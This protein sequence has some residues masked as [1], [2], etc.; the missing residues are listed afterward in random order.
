[1]DRL[2]V[3]IRAALALRARRLG[4]P[5]AP[6]DTLPS[7][8]LVERL[9]V[10]CA[11][12]ALVIERVAAG[13]VI[14]GGAR[15]RL[16]LRNWEKPERGGR[17]WV[18]RELTP[19][20]QVFSI[21]HELG[22]FILHRGE[23]ATP[24]CPDEAISEDANI[25]LLRVAREGLVEEYNPKARREL[26]ANAFAAELLAPGYETRELFLASPSCDENRIA[27]MF[28]VSPRLARARLVASVLSGAE[29]ARE[30]DAPLEGEPPPVLSEDERRALAG[31]LLGDLDEWQREAAK[32]SG[33]AL[34][35]AGPGTGKTKTLVGRVA[36]LYG[37]RGA[38]PENIL[39]LTF[40]NRAADEMR[41]RL[42]AAGLP[43]ERTP[44]MTIHAFATELLRR[45]A[46]YVP[47]AEDEPPLPSDFRILDGLDQL[48][49]AEELL[50][51]LG[52]R[53]LRRLNDPAAPL[54]ELL[55]RFSWARDH[56]LTPDGYR[57]LVDAMPLAPDDGDG[58]E[59]TREGGRG[60]RNGKSA[61]KLPE[62]TF[63]A[64]Q[65]EQAREQ[66]QAY[67]VWDR[68]LRLRGLLD[69]GGL[70]QRA[71]ETLRAAPETLAEA[72]VAFPHVL[73]DEF[74]DTNAAAAELLFLLA[75]AGGKGLWVV[76]DRNQS[77]YRWRGASPNNLPELTRRYPHLTVRTLRQSYRSVPDI[78]RLG[79]DMA[80]RMA[81]LSAEIPAMNGRSADGAAHGP[82]AEALRPVAL[83]AARM[84]NGAPAVWRGEAFP[85]PQAEHAAIIADMLR[86]HADG[87]A[88]SDM[89]ALCYKSKF[90]RALAAELTARGIPVTA[91]G[92]FFARDE[93][94]D[95]LALLR[96][97]ASHDAGGLLRARGLLALQGIRILTG[98]DERAL[99]RAVRRMAGAGAGFPWSLRD[100]DALR[101]V[102]TPEAL[103]PP[104][105]EVG[106]AAADLWWARRG[107]NQRLA[108]LLLRPSGLAWRLAR[109]AGR[110]DPPTAPDDPLG[111]P[112][113]APARARDALAALGALVSLAARFDVRWAAEPG[114]RQQLSGL[115]ARD[116]EEEKEADLTPSPSPERRG[117]SDSSP[118]EEPERVARCFLRYIATLARA[119]DEVVIPPGEEDAVHVLTIH[120][121]KGLEFSAVYLF[122]LAP[123]GFSGSGRNAVDP[124][125][126]ATGDKLDAHLEEQEAERRSLLYVAATRA[127]DTLTITR[128]L[129]YKDNG[130]N[131][132]PPLPAATILDVSDIY[133]SAATLPPADA[134]DYT[135][136]VS[137]DADGDEDD[138]EKD[139]DGEPVILDG[140][141]AGNAKPVFT[142]YALDMYTDCPRRYRYRELY[143]LRDGT[144]PA[145]GA[146][147]RFV[148]RGLDE[149]RRMRAERPD[150]DGDGAR[151]ALATLW[152]SQ[153]DVRGAFGAMYKGYALD[154]LDAEWE[155][156]QD[157][158]EAIRLE[159][160]I[161]LRECAVQLNVDA[162]ITRDPG[163]DQVIL[164]RWH[165]GRP[166]DKH[167]QDP[168]LPLMLMG[169]RQLDPAAHVSVRLVY[170][171]AP[172]GEVGAASAEDRREAA[173][174]RQVVDVTEKARG[175]MNEYLER[176]GRYQALFKLD[177]AAR[178]I[179]EGHFDP[180]P[181]E[182]CGACPFTHICP[183]DLLE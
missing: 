176:R 91:P 20:E 11:P 86:R 24:L 4:G 5:P 167:Q 182:R 92:E 14:L 144:G 122:C 111:E 131:Q 7:L 48:L 98:E 45:Y 109:I 10:V 164:E 120:G 54:P 90:G 52:L 145:V 37:E 179:A 71:V 159:M 72:R 93:I 105:R 84:G 40:S 3:I 121:A 102:G 53:R 124:T 118:V 113:S 21:A 30:P 17:I 27:A 178:R 9:C 163:G 69:Y 60:S 148:R 83:G 152:D 134:A 107:M 174:R 97:A 38:L 58:A 162:L 33:P 16:Q 135:G 140:G 28:G 183:G 137:G 156:T 79:S 25:G 139:L 12:H 19:E 153:P 18:R 55:G 95:T 132:E 34:V 154:I 125:R 39:A 155:R 67:A 88:W 63:S 100:A 181:G 175:Y 169:Y 82:L 157:S 160:E 127:R 22:H 23:G 103:I 6:A 76:G 77:I 70:I 101:A 96:L 75:G 114:F 44:V 41:E 112:G 49:L 116:E 123:G 8:A 29:P 94:K 2:T 130:A 68:E 173:R 180:R 61:R 35:V 161:A 85:T 150:L 158:G 13:D 147:H 80:A 146:F 110:L 78:V 51:K 66:A 142:Y 43:G 136:A 141:A 168:R 59:A 133:A 26:E 104:L 47:H 172:L 143:H 99:G 166:N 106:A 126:P 31:A 119:G 36:Y 73:V 65:I 89:A 1:M 56:L 42:I 177:K 62:G 128:A 32:A 46:S 165:T 74:Q 149:Q 64:D 170:L 50:P 151:Q 117:E 15:A 171:G 87:L 138:D 108:A 57:A 129:T 115:A 81:A